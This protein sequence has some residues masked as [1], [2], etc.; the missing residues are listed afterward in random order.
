MKKNNLFLC[1]FLAL[2]ACGKQHDVQKSVRSFYFWK[3]TLAFNDLQ[4]QQIQD[5]SQKMNI[6]RLYL[7]V[8]DVDWAATEGGAFP[9]VIV[10]ID[11]AALQNQRE[12]VPTVFITNKVFLN[13]QKADCE[14]LAKKV[15]AQIQFICKPFAHK[16]NIKEW[17]FD[18]DWSEGS[19]ANYF[20]FLEKIQNLMPSN[21]QV[22]VTIRLHQWK[23]RTKTGIPPVARG[24]L[25]FYNLTDPRTFT[26][27][28]S[29]LDLEEAR[30]Y[31]KVKGNYPLKMDVVL[32]LFSWGIV[33][34]NGKYE[35]LLNGLTRKMADDLIFLKTQNAFYQVQ[36]DTVFQN[37][38]LRF[39]DLIKIEDI[40]DELL[41]GGAK[42]ARQCVNSDTIHI[43]FFHLDSTILKNYQH[44]NYKTL[45]RIYEIYH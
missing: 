25:M 8:M 37:V 30:K 31:L 16:I 41:R 29:I 6:E 2:L 22:S 14:D 38:Y 45:E 39:G 5:F 21:L 40:S 20:L 10:K 18:C 36:T 17:Q 32:P 43:S 27:Q 44:E 19:R 11:S 35:T 24:M 33:Y 12:I 26:T 3:N 28:N 1:C 42:L 7:R 13:I 23:F 15:A 34:R 4:S 9:K